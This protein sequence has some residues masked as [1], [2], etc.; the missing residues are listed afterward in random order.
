MKNIFNTVFLLFVVIVTLTSCRNN[1]NGLEANNIKG[2][3]IS[4]TDSVWFVN[5]KFG[6]VHKEFLENY[7]KVEFNEDGNI[8]NITEY[9]DD[10]SIKN[11]T[12]RI[13]N[14]KDLADEN[15]YNSDGNLERKSSFSIGDGNIKSC[16]TTFY[17]E[18]NKVEK[19]SYFYTNDKVDSIISLKDGK[20][21]TLTN[22]FFEDE[23]G[24]GYK[25][26]V[27]DYSG[28]KDTSIFYFDSKGRI[29]KMITGGDTY[30][31]IYN[32]NGDL[33]K[34]TY[35]H[36]KNNYKYKYDSKGNWIERIEYEKWANQKPTIKS[37]T[38]RTIEYRKN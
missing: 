24:K 33:E 27:I 25:Q 3:V 18:S 29:T 10:G 1:K 17:N 23:N 30:T 5:E 36:F 6:E 8:T 21:M 32:D 15:Y 38:T 37:Y 12:V 22:S 31:Y 16:I 2:D 7:T 35:S 26:V 11:K 19:S 20:K 34:S 9:D 28:E 4:F 14:G 13:W